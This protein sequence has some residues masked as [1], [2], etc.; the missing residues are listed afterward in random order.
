[1]AVPN[2]TNGNGTNI[3]SDGAN[4]S[5]AV[6]PQAGDTVTF[7]NTSVANC[8]VDEVTAELGSSTIGGTSSG[9]YSGTI[10]GSNKIQMT[11]NMVIEDGCTG[12][13]DMNAD[14][15][16]DGDF[17]GDGAGVTVLCGA[18]TW[19]IGGSFDFK[20]VGTWTRETSKILM[21]GTGDIIGKINLDLF[22]LTIQ[23]G[24]TTTIS[25]STQTLLTMRGDLEIAGNLIL[26]ER[27]VVDRAS[28]I[29]RSTAVVTTGVGEQILL[30]TPQPG[31]G[32]TV[33]EA[34]ASISCILH[35]LGPDAGAVL[36]PGTFDGLVLI[37]NTSVTDGP[38]MRLSNGT[39]NF[40]GG[41][42]MFTQN[43]GD[44]T[45]D[46]KTNA[47]T[48]NVTDV[49]INMDSTGDI[50]IDN[51]AAAVDWNISGN[52]V[53]EITGAGTFTWSPGTGTVTFDGTTNYDGADFG[54]LG[55]VTVA[56]NADLALAT[57]MEC[58]DFVG[59][60]GATVTGAFLL[61]CD[62]FT[63]NGINGNPVTWT[64][65]DVTTTAAGTAAWSD[66]SNS[67]ALP[68]ADITADAN[69][70]NGGGNDAGWLFPAV[71]NPWYQYAQEQAVA[72]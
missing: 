63:L 27:I 44:I 52:V 66:V 49:T 69:S 57:N 10:T 15:D 16:I 67:D 24:A 31:E 36:T 53:D 28:V 8:T 72:A 48:I 1:M 32:L 41:L 50:T 19:T 65:V 55:D 3:W 12:T 30:S 34:G 58:D 71:G 42:E 70:N 61:T 5:T 37:S 26:S 59:A 64:D 9:V 14:I 35:M 6:K 18:G 22:A 21:T 68:G 2:W 46:T 23:N 7:T 47:P 33:F 54:N 40:D 13:L 45:L 43:T 29:L 51:D 38:V 39:Y 4:W 56:A 25:A 20:D 60:Q 62:N 11:G 17:T